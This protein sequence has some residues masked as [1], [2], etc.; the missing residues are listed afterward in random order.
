MFKKKLASISSVLL[1]LAF[2]SST[3][4]A[5]NIRLQS[6]WNDP[7]CGLWNNDGSCCLKCAARSVMDKNGRC[8]PVSD[9]CNTWDEKTGLCTSCYPSFGNPVN[10]VCAGLP[11]TVTDVKSKKSKI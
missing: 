2:L 8:Q 6:G 5:E 9:K 10:G 3:L 7:N 1:I 11:V 4:N